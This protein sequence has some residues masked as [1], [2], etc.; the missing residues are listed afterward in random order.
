[1]SP[2]AG[3]P[4][5]P[6][7]RSAAGAAETSFRPAPSRPELG[8]TRQ[9][10][11]LPQPGWRVFLVRR[12]LGGARE[13]LRRK[14]T[15][16]RVAE[17]VRPATPTRGRP[18]A[19]LPAIRPHRTAGRRRGRVPAGGMPHGARRT[20]G[21]GA[22]GMTPQATTLRQANPTASGPAK[23][24]PRRGAAQP[25]TNTPLSGPAATITQGGGGNGATTA[26]TRLRSTRRDLAVGFRASASSDAVS[27]APRAIPRRAPAAPGGGWR[28]RSRAG[29]PDRTSVGSRS[30]PE[31]GTAGACGA[32][33]R[34]PGGRRRPARRSPPPGQRESCGRQGF[35]HPCR[36][37]PA[38]PATPGLSAN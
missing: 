17:A 5:N 32:R 20:G 18:G 10:G 28:G 19:V 11:S 1:M 37:N 7:R 29:P 31:G 13:S 16:V 8:K 12:H 21:R 24:E 15:G 4:S 33:A 38:G 14:G 35:G 3:N 2:S 27:E 6:S 22:G 26:S 34:R 30:R 25:P 9:T 23:A 36:P